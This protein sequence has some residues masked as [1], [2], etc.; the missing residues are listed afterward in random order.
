MSK[1]SRGIL[2]TIANAVLRPVYRVYEWWLWRQ[3]RNGP[4]PRHV[5]VIPDGNRRWA[6]YLG[7]D[8]KEGHTYGYERLK[9]VLDWLWDLNV[10]AVTIYSTSYENCVKRSKNEL[11]H[12]FSLLRRGVEELVTKGEIDRRRIRVKFFGRLDIVPDDLRELMKEL[13]DYSAKYSER[14]L[15]VAV[16]YG[17]RQEIVDA[18]KRLV[19]DAV[20]GKLDGEID[21]EVFREYLYTSHLSD[22]LEQPDLVIR[23]S[24]EMRISNFLLWQIAYS[25][26]YFCEVYWPEFR[27]IDLWRAIRSF[28]RRERR[29]GA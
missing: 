23:T 27:R 8:P 3:I 17:G 16:C 4:F 12:L 15:N 20:E 24:G 14:Y 19:R 11:D 1:A 28:Q 2:A 22:G 18:V 21:E 10:R 29:F 9:D 25:E 13:E 6:R 5:A 26:L 7:M